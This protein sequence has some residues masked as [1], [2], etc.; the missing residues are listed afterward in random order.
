MG[1]RF[2][3]S[4]VLVENKE[5]LNHFLREVV[6]EKNIYIASSTRSGDC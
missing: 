3:H 1:F 6:H 2:I 4:Q 5:L